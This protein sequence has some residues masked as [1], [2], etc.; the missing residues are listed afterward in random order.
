MRP[1]GYLAL[2]FLLTLSGC[3]YSYD[4]LAV[5]IGGRLAFMVDPRSERSPDCLNA[6]EVQTD[7]EA[8]A[9][10]EPGD[11]FTR[12]AY[13]T[14]WYQRA[15]YKCKTPFPIFYGS[16]LKGGPP[17]DSGVVEN[18]PASEDETGMLARPDFVKPKPLRVGVVYRISTTT[19]STGYGGGAFR[20]RPN[21]TVENLPR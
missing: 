20:I 9:T 21:R 18:L 1:S 14:Y 5:V 6:I 4:I 12:V 11:D 16:A 2:P 3:S 10:P 17:E 13:G 15:S 8:N 19:G 7:E